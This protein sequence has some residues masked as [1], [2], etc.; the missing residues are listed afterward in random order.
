SDNCRSTRDWL[1]NSIRLALTSRIIARLSWSNA[2]CPA[3]WCDVRLERSR[4]SAAIRPP[5]S[6]TITA[7]SRK[8]R[9]SQKWMARAKTSKSATE[10]Q[11]AGQ[12][13]EV[14]LPARHGPPRP[15]VPG[16]QPGDQRVDAQVKGPDHEAQQAEPNTLRVRR[17]HLFGVGPRRG[18]PDAFV[19]QMPD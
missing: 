16:G 7:N 3:A 13:A 1:N 9:A 10:G 18:G 14:R 8:A 5:T 2:S 19:Q 12:V 6:S 4:N 17:G 11:K 15:R